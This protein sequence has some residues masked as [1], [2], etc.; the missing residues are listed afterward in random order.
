MR[1]GETHRRMDAVFT[2]PADPPLPKSY[3]VRSQLVGV[4]ATPGQREVAWAGTIRF[5]LIRRGSEAAAP[6]VAAAATIR[7][8]PLA[9]DS[10]SGRCM[11]R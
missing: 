10:S 1:A 8:T 6:S 11:F 9:N 3:G 7:A 4:V 2:G 5:Q